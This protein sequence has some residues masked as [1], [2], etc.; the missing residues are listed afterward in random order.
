MARNLREDPNLSWSGVLKRM[1]EDGISGG[2]RRAT[3]LLPAAKKLAKESNGKATTKKQG[4][5]R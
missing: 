1:R 2:N 3:R 4:S 5:K